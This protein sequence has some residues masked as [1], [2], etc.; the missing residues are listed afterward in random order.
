MKNNE[1]DYLEKQVKEESKSALEL[2][3][4]EGACRMLHKEKKEKGT[5]LIKCSRI[6][7]Q[8]PLNKPE[9]KEMTG[10]FVVKFIR[11]PASEGGVGGISGGVNGGTD[12]GIKE[13]INRLADYIR[14]TS[15]RNVTEI[16]AALDIPQRTI[17]RWLKKLK[18]QGQIVFSG[19]SK[20]GGYFVSS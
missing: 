1:R 5:V 6:I 14:N 4:R 16:T 15:G 10:A 8:S 19:P 7:E 9:F 11:R 13:G 18:E 17:E 3:I 2:I 12:G 20:S